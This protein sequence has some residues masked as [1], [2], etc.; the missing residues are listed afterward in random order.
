MAD[1]LTKER[2]SQNMAAIRS[3]GMKPEMAVR[4][5]VH[6]LGFR[7]RL[8]R[9]DLPGVPDL[10]F[11]AMKKVIFVHGCF[12]HQHDACREGRLP[13]SRQDYWVPKLTRNVERDA[14]HTA[15]LKKN[16][17]RVLTLWECQ[18][19]NDSRL[20]QTILKFLRSKSAVGT[21]VNRIA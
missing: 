3:M 6:R 21:G 4:S 19:E 20:P 8:H 9:K 15:A 5:L 16:G 12:W 2:R 14:Q 7:F 18:V 11:P 1:K 10:V 13:K 17:W